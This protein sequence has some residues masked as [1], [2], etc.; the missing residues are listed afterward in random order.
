M[1]KTPTESKKF[2]LSEKPIPWF[3]LYSDTVDDD[4]LRLL[5]FED[6]WHFIAI[7][8]CKAKGIIDSSDALLY[9][10]IA[11]RLG[12][13]SREL[14]E[15]ARRLEEVG[16]IDAT[17]LQPIAWDKR[18]FYS[19]TDPTATDRK[20]RQRGLEKIGHP[21]VTRDVTHKSQNVTRTEVEIEEE[22]EV[23]LPIQDSKFVQYSGVHARGGDANFDTPFSGRGKP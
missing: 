19:D 5:A 21:H 10:R 15:V 1:R 8:C 13:S 14:E 18:Q 11:V 12:L 9:R 23:N 4:K 22:I 17:T 6:R 7:L 16:L 20:R 3:R 2:C